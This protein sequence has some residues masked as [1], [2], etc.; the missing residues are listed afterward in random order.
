[1]QSWRHHKIYY[2]KTIDYVKVL[3]SCL[4]S[5]EIKGLFFCKLNSLLYKNNFH[6]S[7]RL[8]SNRSQTTFFSYHT[9][10]SSVIYH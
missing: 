8:F 9:L 2:V 7:V 4:S 6:V 1:M 10:T 5:G 3:F